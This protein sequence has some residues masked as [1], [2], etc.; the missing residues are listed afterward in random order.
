MNRVDPTGHA[1][2]STAGDVADAFDEK[3]DQAN[4]ILGDWVENSG[5]NVV[6]ATATKTAID[7]G[8]G[9]V[10]TL[11]L[12][13]GAAEGGIGGFARDA[14]RTVGLVGTVGQGVRAL[15]PAAR[16][17][18]PAARSGTAVTEGVELVGAGG[19]ANAAQG[20]LLRAQLAAEEAAG[21]RLPTGITG[22][23]RHG[24]N[25]AISR[26]GV[27]VAVR[28]IRDAFNRPLSI[29]GR[30]GERGASFTFTGKDAVVVV[31]GEGKVITTWATNSAGVRVP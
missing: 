20:A 30:A 12:G 29:A 27:G 8:K 1:D 15:A 26:D 22:Y 16:V 24:L 11:R 21:A 19:K 25:Q 13:Q 6:V 31:N 10:D 9:L 14:L 2:I 18:S 28:A 23:T 4:D 3:A 7:L 17:L 5:G